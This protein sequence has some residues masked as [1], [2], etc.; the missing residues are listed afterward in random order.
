MGSV[1]GFQV[2]FLLLEFQG[3]LSLFSYVELCL[4]VLLEGQLKL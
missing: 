3:V 4:L 1:K 2:A